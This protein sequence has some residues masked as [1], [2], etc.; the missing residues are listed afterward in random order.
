MAGAVA[1]I[2][3]MQAVGTDRST[4]QSIADALRDD[5]LEGVLEPG[6]RL[7][8]ESLTERFGSGRHSV[9]SALQILVAEGLLEHRRNRGIV[10]PD[11]T[12]QRVDEM[13]SYRS[14]LEMGALRLA[15]EARADFSR[16]VEAV[17]YLDSLGPNTPWRHVIEAHSAVHQRMV[18]ASGNER[19]V[20]AHAACENELN[21][22]LAI[23]QA[24]FTAHRL[25]LMHRE[26][27]D[28]LLVGGDAA[29]QALEHDLEQGGRAAMHAALQKREPLTA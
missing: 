21:Y 27:V 11:V 8:E 14:I 16:V 26:L 10:V 18:E 6:S 17:D 24:D 19:L 13:C 7:T 3:L 23:I 20:I 5:L 4:P 12:M 28:Q 2:R 9:R 25:A 15:L 22:M 29:L 1:R